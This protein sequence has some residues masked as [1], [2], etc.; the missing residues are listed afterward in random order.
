MY[1]REGAYHNLSAVT[2]IFYAPQGTLP[3]SIGHT[4]TDLAETITAKIQ[5]RPSAKQSGEKEAMKLI[6]FHYLS[7][8]LVRLFCN[9]G[10]LLVAL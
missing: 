2:F 7:F 10:L 9:M 5:V 3:R 1:S 6:T 8:T 4:L